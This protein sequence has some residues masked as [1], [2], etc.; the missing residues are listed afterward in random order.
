LG[1]AA[2]DQ[3]VYYGAD[4]PDLS[5]FASRQ[6]KGVG[7][8]TTATE[9]AGGRADWYS[10]RSPRLLNGRLYAVSAADGKQIWELAPLRVQ[11]S[12]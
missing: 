10:G 1:R 11:Y 4:K 7:L 8:R 9:V 3:N 2:D 6:E 5:R 12:E